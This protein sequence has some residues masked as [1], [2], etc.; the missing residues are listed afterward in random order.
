MKRSISW[1][2]ICGANAQGAD[3]SVHIGSRSAVK[4][5]HNKENESPAL[6]ITLKR[7]KLATTA[8]AAVDLSSCEQMFES[9]P[10]KKMPH[11]YEVL[12]IYSFLFWK[13]F[14]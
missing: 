3:E 11:S 7:K 1:S 8:T 14:N 9:T 12:F 13:Y 2:C 10:E 5:K 6:N 4:R